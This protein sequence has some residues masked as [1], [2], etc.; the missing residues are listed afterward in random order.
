M[1]AVEGAQYVDYKARQY[2]SLQSAGLVE[3]G[4]LTLPVKAYAAGR[5]AVQ[6]GLELTG[7]QQT[8]SY[9]EGLMPG[10]IDSGLSRIARTA[11][12]FSLLTGRGPLGF[13]GIKAGAKATRAL[14]LPAQARRLFGRKGQ[15]A[16]TALALGASLINMTDVTETSKHLA[17]VYSGDINVK[18][19]QARWW[20]LG[21]QPFGGG[22]VM[23]ERPHWLPTHLSRARTVGRYGS[24]AERWRNSFLPTPESWF[25]TR[26]LLDPYR[27]E[28]QNYGTRPYPLTGPLFSEVPFVG[29][30]LAATVGEVLKPTQKWH[31]AYW[32]GDQLV[33]PGAG[34]IVAPPS[35][36][37]PDLAGPSLRA[38]QIP[39]NPA[40][41]SQTTLPAQGIE[42]AAAALGYR[43]VAGLPRTDVG[44]PGSVREVVG[45][46]IDVLRDFLGMP[47][48]LVGALKSKVTGQEDFNAANRQ[49]ETAGR[50]TSIE[51][52]YYEQQMGGGLGMTELWRR[53]HPHRRRQIELV[54]PIPN[55]MAEWLPGSYSAFERDRRSRID[56]HRGDPYTKI[57]YG[58]ARLPGPGYEVLHRL[59]SG[60][61]GVYDPYD[62]WKI[63]RD[64]AP[65]SQAF[66]N[67][68]TLVQ[69]WSKAKAF[70][71]KSEGKL[72]ER[73]RT[74]IDPLS[75]MALTGQPTDAQEAL[76]WDT[77][78]NLTERFQPYPFTERIFDD[79]SARVPR[80]MRTLA[81]RTQE[82]I[83]RSIKQ[84]G[85]YNRIEKL[86]GRAWEAVSHV[87]LPG[88]LNWPV[89]KL[90]AQRDALEVYGLQVRGGMEFGDWKTPVE[91]F[92]VPWMHQ[93][94]GTVN[95]DF[96]QPRLQRQR[97]VEQGLDLLQFAKMR[98]RP[99]P[100]DVRTWH[101]ATG[102]NRCAPLPG[103]WLTTTGKQSSPDSRRS[104]VDTG[105]PSQ[106]SR[107]TIA[108]R[109]S[110]AL[111][112]RTWASH[113]GKS[114]A[115]TSRTK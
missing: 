10:L 60:I 23:Y 64:I 4:P 7:I 70:D 14:N 85:E 6:K 77:Q 72:T 89:N 29:P 67:Y 62:R 33:E 101:E 91:S 8:T 55:Q 115:T 19:R 63:L 68:N 112:R 110:S 35:L 75:G 54:N 80:K 22:R 25:G 88:P 39:I 103:P 84:D 3:T 106:L 61:P 102:A 69:A 47:G 114:G 96:I 111:C 13:L 59:H 27:V 100:L 30:A 79:P 12:T 66:R 9:L 104:N 32:Q 44:H 26:P 83:N 20:S 73:P 76:I 57:D 65:G 52:Q 105:R 95:S 82:G 94:Q 90:F 45:K 50:I 34:G 15:A 40:G 93:A 43:Q 17:G 51:R 107:T 98:S 53:F 56:F 24:E 109:R 97:M 11:A 87:T 5:V 16:G 21:S 37:R 42:D 46:Q 28:K 36:A 31:G 41:T 113:C 58:E 78:R 38:G 49:I 86:V 108:A 99:K 48:F 71:K 18:V 1:A 2:T 92:L 74:P 81:T